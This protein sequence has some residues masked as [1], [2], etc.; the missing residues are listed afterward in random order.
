MTPETRADGRCELCGSADGLEALPVPP[1][2]GEAVWACSTCRVQATGEQ[3]LDARHWRCL[4]ESAWSDVP[5]VQV[6]AA[7]LLD[8]LGEPWATDLRQQLYLDEDTQAWL[9]ADPRGAP[10]VLD[11]HGTPL[12][13]GDAVTLI[14]D[15]DVK[16]ANFTAK[17][18][19]TVKSIRLTDDPGLVEGRVNGT[20]IYLKV[21][22]LKKLK[23]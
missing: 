22:F 1:R 2:E 3:D 17:R 12:D 13:H 10:A 23:A 11:A 16:G 15:L 14:K 6:T 5:A 19:T 7:R 21:E 8:A 9:D 18:G 20:A 4:N